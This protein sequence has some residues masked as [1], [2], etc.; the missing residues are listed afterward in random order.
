MIVVNFPNFPIFFEKK[1][2][3]KI[4]RLFETVNPN[5]FRKVESLSVHMIFEY[6]TWKLSQGK[7]TLR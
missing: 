6:F 5:S 1:S 2:E 3:S 4:H 7:N